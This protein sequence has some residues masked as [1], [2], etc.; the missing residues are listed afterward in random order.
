M[1]LLCGSILFQE[2]GSNIS[3]IPLVRNIIK[4]HQHNTFLNMQTQVLKILSP[5]PR[6]VI[7]NGLFVGKALLETMK[8]M[9]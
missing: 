2:V 9:K 1:S 7:T 4:P 8:C 5:N 3:D 6:K